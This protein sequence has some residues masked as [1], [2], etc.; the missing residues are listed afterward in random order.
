MFITCANLGDTVFN[1]VVQTITA[2]GTVAQNGVTFVANATSNPITL[3]VT[4]GFT[5]IAIKDM[6]GNA[7][8]Y[9]ITIVSG[10]GSN[11]D[12][13]A[14]YTISVNYGWVWLSDNGTNYSVVG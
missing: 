12:A 8:A 4:R 6:S 10:D 7:Q 1:L 2:G 13:S 5:W 9:P 11:I 3:T 14:S